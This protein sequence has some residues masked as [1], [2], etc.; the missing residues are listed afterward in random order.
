MK[1]VI[2]GSA[3]LQDKINLWRTVFSNKKYEILDY[4]KPIE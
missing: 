1:I 2:V 4:S 3:K